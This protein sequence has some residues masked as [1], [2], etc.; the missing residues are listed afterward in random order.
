MRSAA[1]FVSQIGADTLTSM[2]PVDVEVS[3]TAAAGTVSVGP[4]GGWS[5]AKKTEFVVASDGSIDGIGEMPS[6]LQGKNHRDMFPAATFHVDYGMHAGTFVLEI[7]QVSPS[8]AHLV[9]TLDGQ[10]AVERDL[11]GG[12]SSNPVIRL[13]VAAGKHEIKVENT[14]ADWLVIQRIELS[15]Y[16]TALKALGKAGKTHAMIW[17]R[18]A[19]SGGEGIEGTVSIPGLDPGRY[20]IHWWDTQIGEWI[21]S[22][23]AVV[24]SGG[25]IRV[26]TPK[27]TTDLA[28]FVQVAG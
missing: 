20:R 11:A 2:L 22:D 14:G 19:S 27:V 28:A 13:S 7:G 8:G 5:S 6:Y 15:P 24:E 12:D 16:G 17:V 10:A 21:R 23:S 1:D 25:A 9:I 18:R 26:A 4:G 3:T